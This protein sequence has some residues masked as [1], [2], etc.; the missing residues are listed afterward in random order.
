MKKHIV[1]CSLQKKGVLNLAVLTKDSEAGD[2]YH[3][4]EITPFQG[5]ELARHLLNLLS[6]ER[7]MPD[8]EPRSATGDVQSED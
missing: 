3:V 1:Y 8:E 5:Q 2:E 7:R 6:E 4:Y